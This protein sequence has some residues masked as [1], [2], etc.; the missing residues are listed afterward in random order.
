MTTRKLARLA[1]GI[2]LYAVLGMTMNIPLLAG[3]HLQTDL[4]YAAFGAFCLL[5][6]WQAFVVGVFGCLIESLLISGWVPIGWMA[7]QLAIGLVCGLVYTKCNSKVLHVVTTIVMVFV[8]IAV[9]K[10]GIECALYSIPVE[11]K[12]VK[13]CVAFVADTIPML[14]GLFAGYRIKPI[15]KERD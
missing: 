11:I 9:I 13:N 15:I 3:T 7:G 6:G 4:G 14:A 12:F 10:T 8:G 1:M 5:F 2:A